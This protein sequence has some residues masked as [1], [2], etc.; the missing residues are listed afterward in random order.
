MMARLSSAV[1]RHPL[2]CAALECRR[3]PDR[4][5]PR[6]IAQGV[7]DGED[8]DEDRDRTGQEGT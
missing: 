2:L 5:T 6:P 4:Y 7:D 3:P 1:K 8:A